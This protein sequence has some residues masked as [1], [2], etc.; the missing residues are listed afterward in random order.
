[1]R[2]R[3]ITPTG[4]YLVLTG[5]GGRT[6]VAT[7]L[8][9]TMLTWGAGGGVASAVRSPAAVDQEHSVQRRQTRTRR[10][11]RGQQAEGGSLLQC[12][13]PSTQA[14]C[15]AAG[16]CCT[17]K[18]YDILADLPDSMKCGL[19]YSD[20][21][22]AFDGDLEEK[23]RT[24]TNTNNTT[25]DETNNSTTNNNNNN[26]DG[27]GADEDEVEDAVRP[28]YDD[29]SF[30]GPPGDYSEYDDND[31][32]ERWF[33]LLLFLPLFLLEVLR[34][35]RKADTAAPALNTDPPGTTNRNTRGY[36][37][38]ISNSTTVGGG[39]PV[40]ELPA[41][42]GGVGPEMANSRAPPSPVA[43]ATTV[44]AV[45]VGSARAASVV[46]S[47]YPIAAAV[48]APPIV[49]VEQACPVIKPE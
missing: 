15:R 27:S 30:S 2:T 23:D 49:V 43:L 41:Y 11:R 31:L 47:A 14:A 16:P 42:S 34:R 9:L 29:Y 36:T 3:I 19:S 44:T 20:S 17:W 46:V 37:A 26:E 13:G 7:I 25:N 6:I 40:L 39:P 48:S 22:L 4:G 24:N 28:S 18:E 12:F 1:M 10:R 38:T 21:C 32:D 8:M 5:S 35:K 45:A 33:Y